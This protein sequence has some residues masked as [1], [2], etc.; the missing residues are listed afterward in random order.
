M[1]NPPKWQNDIT[2]PGEPP[3][4]GEKIKETFLLSLLNVVLPSID[5][6][7]DL[8]LVVNFYIGSRHNPYC[9]QKYPDNVLDDTE[10]YGTYFE[11]WKTFRNKRISCYYDDNVPTSNVTFN[12]HYDWGTMILLPFLLNYLICWYAWATTDKRK[13]VT[14]VAG[15]LN[16]YPQYIACKI[17]WHIWVDPRK[18]L[19]KKR[20][21]ER[22]L[23]QLETFL[24]AVPSSLIMA[25]LLVRAVASVKGSE[26]IFN[27]SDVNSFDSVLFLIAFSTSVITS[28]L[29]LAKNLKVGPCQILPSEQKKRRCL[30]GFLSPQFILIFFACGLT[31]VSKAYALALTWELGMIQG[32]ALAV[33]TIFLPGFLVG[34]FSC[35][36][37]GILKTFLAHPS[38][39]LMPLFTCVT[40]S[41]V[42]IGEKTEEI[43]ITFS[44]KHTA[45]NVGVSLVGTLIHSV[46][47]H[48]FSV[49]FTLLIFPLPMIS[50]GVVY[51]LVFTFCNNCNC[52]CLC[53]EPFEVAAL[54]T[55]SPHIP[56]HI[57]EL[58]E[59]TDIEENINVEVLENEVPFP[60]H[61]QIE[62]SGRPKQ[63]ADVE[64][65][66]ELEFLKNEVPSPLLLHHTPIESTP[67]TPIESS[68]QSKQETDFIEEDVNHLSRVLE[69]DQEKISKR[70]VREDVNIE[71]PGKAVLETVGE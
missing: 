47:L 60:S 5:V 1:L 57:L 21:F 39:F 66:V 20:D 63:E 71:N 29:G 56:H 31:L 61:T 27:S 12:P 4:R 38:V 49:N 37:R 45:I 13:S 67:H 54:V 34:L 64:E 14:W 40:N 23:V 48:L 28:S 6:Y 52:L 46:I 3:S 62:S 50:L 41:M 35:W 33:T 7:S 68:R 65:N 51:T 8:A 32:A 25:F 19:Q 10:Q 44:P 30:G 70:S 9:D 55:S 2:F 42:C 24:E 59:E 58:E 17:I 16:C 43:Y 22:N 69:E 11:Q 18:G 53:S 15:L 26:I 36:H